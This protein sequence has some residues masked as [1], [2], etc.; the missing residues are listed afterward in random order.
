[1]PTCIDCRFFDP[2]GKKRLENDDFIGAL[3]IVTYLRR[4]KL[5]RSISKSN[6]STIISRLRKDAVF[7]ENIKKKL[8]DYNID[9][10]IDVEET[11]NQIETDF[12]LQIIIYTRSSLKDNP[13][14]VRPS[15]GEGEE[16]ILIS[17]DFLVE[18]PLS[19]YTK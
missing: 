5:K 16:M 9:G 4:E 8:Q 3:A 11:L 6:Q 15:N 10:N 19:R 1:M 2:K 14:L 12:N 18:N 7:F 13:K 17:K